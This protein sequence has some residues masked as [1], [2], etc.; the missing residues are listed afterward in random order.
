M[1]RTNYARTRPCGH[2]RRQPPLVG[3][4]P[5]WKC[6]AAAQPAGPAD[7]SRCAPRSGRVLPSGLPRH[8]GALIVS[9]RPPSTEGTAGEKWPGV[10]TKHRRP[11]RSSSSRRHPGQARRAVELHDCHAIFSSNARSFSLKPSTE[12]TTRPSSRP[13]AGEQP[14]SPTE[15]PAWLTAGLSWSSCP[16]ATTPLAGACGSEAPS[17]VGTNAA[18]ALVL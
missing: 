3:V 15:L 1:I 9:S 8:W 12:I 2:F 13:K 7:L 4:G 5:R 6:H 16:A 11:V 14:Y 10:S 18:S 17:P